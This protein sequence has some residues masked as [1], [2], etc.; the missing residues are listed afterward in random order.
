MK[1]IPKRNVFHFLLVGGLLILVTVLHY[2]TPYDEPIFHA[3][4]RLL[5]YVPIILAAFLWGKKGA[6]VLSVIINIVYL[7]HII[8]GWGHIV[9]HS[10]IAILEIV[11]YYAIG[12]ITGHLIDRSREEA[13]KREEMLDQFR[14]TEMESALRQI[15]YVITHEL[16]TPLASISGAIDILC[17]DMDVSDEKGKFIHILHSETMRINDLLEHTLASFSSGSIRMQQL[18]I[19]P[20]LQ[21]IKDLLSVIQERKQVKLDLSVEPEIKSLVLDKDLFKEALINLINNSMEAMN[22]TGRVELSVTYDDNNVIFSVTDTGPGISSTIE[23]DIFKPF[24]TNKKRGK[25][26][27][28]S[29]VKRIVQLHK[30]TV[31]WNKEYTQGTEFIIK[32]P[33]EIMNHE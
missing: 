19:I 27:G 28:L 14:H 26:L 16:K 17:Q 8:I 13:R 5:Y 2:L 32:L 9:M 18:E 12:L 20:Y 24:I 22:N 6:V 29:I 25:G 21:E 30:G 3:I 10:Y 11:M 31:S 4:Y 23:R 33:R 15:S 1:T 7:P